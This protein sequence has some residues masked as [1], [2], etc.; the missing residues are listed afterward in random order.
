MIYRDNKFQY[1][2]VLT[3]THA[4]IHIQALAHAHTLTDTCTHNQTRHLQ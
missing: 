4:A 2:P 3:R 1:C